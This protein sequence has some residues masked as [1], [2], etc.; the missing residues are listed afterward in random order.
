MQYSRI[1]IAL[2]I[3]KCSTEEEVLKACTRLNLLIEQGAQSH[4]CLISLLAKKR[5]EYLIT[6]Q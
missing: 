6:N 2:I 3:A 4:L 5:I 1:E